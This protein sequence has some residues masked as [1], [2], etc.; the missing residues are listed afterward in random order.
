MLRFALRMI[1]LLTIASGFA[2]LVVDGTRTIA[3]SELSLT[4]FAELIK[5]RL[6][7]LELIVGRNIHPF[8]WD[9]LLLSLLKL[10]AWLVLSLVGL[11]FLWLASRRP[12]T[13]SIAN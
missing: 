12:G 13:V 10:P 6:P 1:G 8:L 3:G 7:A 9:P 11:I 2:A 4:P 5:A